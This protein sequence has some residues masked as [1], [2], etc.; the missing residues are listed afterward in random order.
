M[1]GKLIWRFVT[2]LIISLT[3][4]A[5]ISAGH[6]PIRT[7]TSAD[8]LGSSFVNSIMRDSQGFLWICTRDGLSRFDG[9]QFV[10]YQIGDKNAPPGIES[11][12]ETHQGIYWIVTT[13]GLYK[14]DPRVLPAEVSSIDRP[15]LNAEFISDSRFT[16]FEDRKGQLWGGLNPGLFRLQENGGQAS[17]QKVELKSGRAINVTCFFESTDGSL[18]IGS[19][20][21]LLR[22]LPD[23][24][25]FYYDFTPDPHN[26]I[27]ALAEDRDGKIWVGRASGIYA[28]KPESLAEISSGNIPAMRDFDS[29]TRVQPPSAKVSLP[30][31]PGEIF[32]YAFFSDPLHGKRFYQANDGHLWISDGSLIVDFDGQTLSVVDYGRKSIVGGAGMVLDASGNLWLATAT[33]LL[34]LDRHGLVS[35]E[36]DDGL[37]TAGIFAIGESRSGQVYV[38]GDSFSL[39][40][41]DGRAFASIR[42]PVPE[43]AGTLWT[44]NPVYQDRFGEWWILT[45]EGLFHFAAQDD[46]AKLAGA[47]PLDVFNGRNGLKGDQIFHVFEDSKG[48][49]W[50]STRDNDQSRWGLSKWDHASRTFY[51]FSEAEGF[52]SRKAVSSFVEDRNGVLWFGLIDGG[53]LRYTQDRFSE[54]MV[55]LPATLITALHLDQHGRIWIASAQGGVKIINDPAAARP[56]YTDFTISNGLASNNVRSMTEDS[57]GYVYVGTA[58]GVDK[59]S[60]D[61]SQVSH[62]SIANGLSGDF[63]NSAFRDSR[64]TLWFG[65]PSGLSSL[66]PAAQRNASAPPIRLSGLRIAGES[67]AVAQLGST[68]ISNLE[69]TSGQNNLQVDFFAIDFG[70]GEALRYQYRLEGADQDWSAPSGQRTVNYSNLA[71]GTYRFLVRAIN[72]AGVSSP[73]PAVVSFSIR[74]PFWRRWWFVTLAIVLL[75]ATVLAVDRYRVRRLRALDKLN[76]KLALE[77]DITRLLAESSSTIEAAP[78][79]L[80]LICEALGWEVGVIWDVDVEADVLRCVAVWHQPAVKAAE[81]EARTRK[82][83]FA[84]GE[85]LPGRVW[86]SATPQWIPDL[87]ADKNFPRIAVAAQEGLRSGFSFPILVGAEV[88]GVIEFFKREMTQPDEAVLEMIHPIG[89]EIGQL[90][91]RKQSEQALRQSETRFRTLAESASDAIITIDANSIIVY[92][93]RAAENIFGYP[94]EEM[95]GQDLT[96]LM[97]EYLRHVHRAGLNRY[98]ETGKRH[99]A[100]SSVELP[101]LHKDGHEIPL[102]L[103]FGEFTRNDQR[104]FTG[105]ARDETQRKQAEEELLRTREARAAELERV[106]KRIASDLHDDIGSSLTQISLLSEVVNQ[107]LDTSDLAVTQPLAAI[108]NSSRELVDAMSDIVW[109]INPQK[110][111]LSDLTQ[112]MRTLTSEV[113]TAGGIKVRFRSPEAVAD[114]PLGANLRR[115]VFLIFKECV[116]N[117]VK[118]SGAT[119]ADVDFRID[120]RQLFLRV[121]DNGQGFEVAA[122]REGHGLTSMQARAREM[123]GRFEITS[124][125]GEGTVVTL[126]V[127]FGDAQP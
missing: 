16:L 45:T 111:H 27:T 65:T 63:I 62:Y 29:L 20:S 125:H 123:G 104:Y 84:R 47:R 88:I 52:P 96:M 25:E 9:A 91:R 66:T 100:W 49:L 40:R 4:Q 82:Q 54:V 92:I 31:K 95:L 98:V 85:G 5:W 70:A 11:I 69:L 32:K 73:E 117:I 71:P 116:N 50:I 68:S 121:E 7:Y 53:L 30:E 26:V 43:N 22:R 79:I 12:L 55:D 127:P 39:S 6:L 113:S 124:N 83:T 56:S 93:N 37:S 36:A 110:D 115:E 14:F 2:L 58:R 8:G 64:G 33:G 89:A 18:W 105:I 120:A 90:L 13:A 106:R 77:Y 81:F 103:S 10:T 118:H 51:T 60:P 109:A 3:A 114:L 101:G 24:A 17:W 67:R 42:A 87:A 97:P 61:L 76:R 15:R 21:T 119:E 38:V 19:Y 41:F 1:P 126:A 74:P 122:E 94:V 112:R 107:R 46:P 102:E 34:R 59:I 108:A 28:I 44:S 99:I 80:K 23:G 72:S 86:N 48:A 75:G 35:Y 78:G 57:F